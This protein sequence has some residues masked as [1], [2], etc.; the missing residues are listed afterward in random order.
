[1]RP[2]PPG[3]DAGVDYCKIRRDR[4]HHHHHH[5]NHHGGGGT[6]RRSSA[7]SA[8]LLEPPP[9]SIERYHSTVE[10]H[11][12][13]HDLALDRYV[14]P[15]S[16]ERYST[17]AGRY[18]QHHQQHQQPA[19]DRYASSSSASSSSCHGST[20]GGGGRSHYL[21]VSQSASESF[22]SPPSPVAERFDYAARHHDGYATAAKRN[23]S[24]YSR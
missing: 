2:L 17:S 19:D 11:Y 9:P 23:E 6:L 15:P 5:Q 24:V 22:M 21:P 16:P 1:M 8:A 12:R 13:V 14:P 7:S 3:Q 20:G 10:G 18:R 4:N